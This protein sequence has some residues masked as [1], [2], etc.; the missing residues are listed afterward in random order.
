MVYAL[1][2]S[3]AHSASTAA[4]LTGTALLVLLALVSTVM[5]RRSPSDLSAA[6]LSDEDG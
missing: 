6:A 4:L 5:L 2:G 1:F 3:S